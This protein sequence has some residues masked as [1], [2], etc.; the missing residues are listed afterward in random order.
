MSS[1]PVKSQERLE[2][3]IKMRTLISTKLLR[4][5]A[6][7]MNSKWPNY[8]FMSPLEATEL[9]RTHYTAALQ[10]YVRVNFD[11]QLARRVKGV[12][13]HLPRQRTGSFTQLW[14]ARQFADEWGLPYDMFL[15]FCFEFASNRKRTWSPLP[16]QL[17]PTEKQRD[18]WLSMWLEYANDQLGVRLH[19]LN[20]RPQFRIE[21]DHGLHPQSFF[22]DFMQTHFRQLTSH[23]TERV[24]TMAIENRVLSL[25]DCLAL[26]PEDERADIK[27]RVLGD[28]QRGRW[29]AAPV[30]A[31]DDE[32]FHVACF[33]VLE[34]VDLAKEPC[35]TCPL[36]DECAVT[37]ERA[38][39]ETMGRTGSRSPVDEADR[40]RN[41]RNVAAHR[42]RKSTVSRASPSAPQTSR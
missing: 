13:Q 18:A 2:Q 11:T 33:G 40:E 15:A 32:D 28:V 12:Q 38:A 29:I 3:L 21:H 19:E 8:R 36:Y 6:E 24:G 16:G 42:A 26:I 25:D 22:R 41:R 9:F 35:A 30:E 14:Q 20:Q 39:A 27:A 4:R 10:F 17:K 23:W 5:E 1:N 37:A 34:S 31:L 7:L